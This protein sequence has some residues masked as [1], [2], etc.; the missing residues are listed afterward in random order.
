MISALGTMIVAGLLNPTAYGEIT[1]AMVPINFVLLFRDFGVTAALT[2]NISQLRHENKLE[3]V[4]II[5]RT[6]LAINTV[7]GVFLT[8][9]LFLS[10]EFLS[11]TVFNNS[12]IKVLIQIASIDVISWNLLTAAKAI[13]AGYERMEL[14]SM[15]TIIYS[16]LRSFTSPLLVY[17]NYG[18]F[19]AVLGHS[20][21]LL[22][23]GLIGLTTIIA[24]FSQATE[25]SPSSYRTAAKRIFS[26]GFPLL[27][28]TVLGGVLS[29]LNNF[30][31]AIYSD[32]FSIGNYSAAAN[33]GVLITFFTLP[34]ATTLFPLF[35][36]LNFEEDGSLKTIYQLSVKYVSIISLP[37]VAGMIALSEQII[38][39]VYPPNYHLASS[40]LVLFALNFTFIAMG[41][42]GIAN[43]LKSQGRTDVVFRST[44]LNVLMGGI[45]GFILIP[46]FGITGLLLSQ[47]VTKAG[48]FYM[49]YWTWQNYGFSFDWR[50]SLKILFSAGVSTISVISLLNLLN[51]RPWIEFIL[52]GVL[53]LSIYVMGIVASKAVDLNDL[54]NLQRIT[55][56]LG[57]LTKFFKFL[58]DII[59]YLVKLRG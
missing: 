26:Y 29:H 3:E 54:N 34:V 50:S 7:I 51:L 13:F 55:V 10:S 24:F 31:V 28:S 43:L 6:G 45:L 42:V 27:L 38:A 16:V 9:I 12:S 36:K 11:T 14:H 40:F 48:L 59:D 18:A 15:L 41:R 32:T 37:I 35:S 58:F 30:L 20:I 17:L 52:G 23:V 47:L 49:L 22:F 39:I 19:G 46:R 33:F 53:L 25:Q 5:L 21:S 1:V 57:P 44:L 4:K 2:R 56:G 8:I